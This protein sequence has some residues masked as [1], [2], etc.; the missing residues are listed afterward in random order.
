VLVSGSRTILP[1]SFSRRRVV[2]AAAWLQ[3]PAEQASDAGRRLLV[4]S[5][6]RWAVMARAPGE[7]WE[8]VRQAH[9]RHQSI[10]RTLVSVAQAHEVLYRGAAESRGRFV[11]RSKLLRHPTQV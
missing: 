8:P 9:R 2:A 10:N 7:G 3:G 11:G 1:I 5:P 6:I 4:K